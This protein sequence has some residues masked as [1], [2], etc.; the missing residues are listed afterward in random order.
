LEDRAILSPGGDGV[1]HNLTRALRAYVQGRR[2][3]VAE[4]I[5][6]LTRMTRDDRLSSQD[7]YLYVYYYLHSLVIPAGEGD[8]LV[9]KLTALSKALKHVQQRATRIDDVKLRQSYLRANV[10]NAGL[11]DDAKKYKLM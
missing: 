3:N 7:P 5:A 11:L 9:N 8:L 4:G 6:E 10:G 1:L 2:D